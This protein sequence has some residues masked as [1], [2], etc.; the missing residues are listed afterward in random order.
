MSERVREVL[1]EVDHRCRS[2]SGCVVAV[3][4]RGRK[5]FGDRF[6]AGPDRPVM[7][8][9]YCLDCGAT[10]VTRTVDPRRTGGDAL[11]PGDVAL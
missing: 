8:Y 4:T 9:E 2:C 1:G 6:R 7:R 3:E 10:V 11:P 5:R